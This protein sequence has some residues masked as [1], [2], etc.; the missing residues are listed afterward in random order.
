[1][2]NIDHKIL[3]ELFN[4][5]IKK[6]QFE[7]DRSKY[8]RNTKSEKSHKGEIKR[9]LKQVKATKKRILGG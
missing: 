1:M 3:L 2:K 9:K 6:L 8:M 7:F 5:E 4:K